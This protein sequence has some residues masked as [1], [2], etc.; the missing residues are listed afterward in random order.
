M[1]NNPTTIGTIQDVNGASISIVLN[2]DLATGFT[3][4]NGH[5]YRVG[6]L[7]SFIR[8]SVGYIELYGVVSHVGASA[9]PES[10]QEENPYGNKWMKAQLIGESKSGNSFQRGVSQF[11]TIGDEVHIVSERDLERVYG[12]ID[13]KEYV[14]VGYIAGSE[15]IPAIIDINKLVARHSAVVGTTGSG[16][17][18]TVASLL[19]SLSDKENYPSSRIIVFDIHGEY[20][21]ALSDR[22]NVFKVGSDTRN[23][24]E[25]E[26]QIPFWALQ[27]DELVPLCFGEFVD[28][29][30]KHYVM[31]RI[32]D[33]KLRVVESG[34]N[35]DTVGSVDLEELDADTPIPFSINQL[36]HDLYSE[37]FATYYKAGSNDPND[38]GTWA[39]L[40]DSNG[41]DI[42]GNAESAIAPRFKQVKNESSDPEKIHFKPGAQNIRKQLE[43]LGSKL[44]LP[45]FDF[46]FKVGPWRPD[47][48][49]KVEKD[50]DDLMAQWLG[51]E[52]P[53]TIFDFSGVPASV[54]NTIIGVMSR[55]LFDSFL[56]SR[57]HPEGG[58][59]RP[60]L[61]VMEEA[62]NYLNDNYKGYA[63][64]SVQKLVKEGR[65]Y[66]IGVMIVSQRP[67]EINTTI[68]SQCGTFFAL[69]LSNSNDRSHVTS[70]IADN[71]EGLT[72]ML[73]ILRT[74]ETIIIG[75]AVQLPMRAQILAPPKDKRPDSHDPVVYSEVI[76][77]ENVEKVG[78]GKTLDADRNYKSF[79]SAWR[80]QNIS[81]EEP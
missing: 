74:G 28:D 29:K 16:K 8:V 50:L 36:W 1:S 25:K 65:K 9:V 37:T 20:G 80:R 49:G 63:S 15:S 32:I 71:L 72:S 55:L 67:S 31:E 60:L 14:Q 62:H 5:G 42:T 61:M 27:Y 26:L 19:R 73:P 2:D 46:L 39:F 76:R 10:K 64:S 18:T 53:I 47:N 79:V 54:L 30:T 22:A 43:A 24:N 59:K 51:G 66:G 35:G 75:E 6:Q 56:W 57:R 81:I 45:R 11:P 3:Y 7:G 21:S 13:S 78:W 40:K 48:T 58:R 34:V 33:E 41:N 70:V 23:D 17:S 38:R 4:F 69:R 44:R 52:K 77:N 68:L 12:K